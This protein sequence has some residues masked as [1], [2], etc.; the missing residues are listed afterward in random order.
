MHAGA[1]P[2]RPP[3]QAPKPVVPAGA[4]GAPTPPAPTAPPKPPPLGVT[5]QYTGLSITTPVAPGTAAVLPAGTAAPASPS[6][7]PPAS[8]LSTISSGTPQPSPS[9]TPSPGP[10]TKRPAS[11]AAGPSGSAVGSAQTP[12]RPSPTKVPIQDVAPLEFVLGGVGDPLRGALGGAADSEADK[13]GVAVTA[14]LL[15]ARAEAAA[16]AQ[17][18]PLGDAEKYKAALLLA[19]REKQVGVGSG[20]L[21]FSCG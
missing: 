3:K 17:G 16:A 4:P 6:L 1:V 2:E 10:G 12:S 9:P 7:Q 14:G 20:T 5:A 13:Q 11:P 19:V 8:P 15:V 18:Q 21:Y